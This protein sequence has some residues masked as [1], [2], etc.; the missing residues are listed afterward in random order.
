MSLTTRQSTIALVLGSAA[1]ILVLAVGTVTALKSRTTTTGRTTTTTMSRAAL[2]ASKQETKIAKIWDRFADGY[3]K[4]PIEDL[5]SYE[6]KLKLTRKYL[7]PERTKTVLEFGCGTGG[8][9]LLHAPYAKSIHA[10]DISP[11]MIEI[12]KERQQQQQQQ[13]SKTTTEPEEEP[14]A[15]ST[16]TTENVKFECTGID[17]L[18]PNN[19]KK[20]DQEPYDIIMGM[21]ILHLLPNLNE[22]LPKVHENLRSDGYF[23]SSTVCMGD[24]SAKPYLRWILPVVSWTGIIPSIVLFTK[25]ELRQR[26]EDSGFEIEHEFHPDPEKAVFLVAKKK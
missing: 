10:I 26:I 16:T 20:E 21:S 9:A 5:E 12:A 2:V 13:E 11:R 14:K 7:L 18:S 15:A 8:T 19:K 24:W 25:Q 6:I 22:I 1:A 4:Q 23:I 17:S 3:A